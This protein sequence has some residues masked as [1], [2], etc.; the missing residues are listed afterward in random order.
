MRNLLSQVPKQAQAVTAAV[1][2][3][4]FVQPTANDGAMGSHSDGAK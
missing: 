1:I 3:T 4:I 2:R